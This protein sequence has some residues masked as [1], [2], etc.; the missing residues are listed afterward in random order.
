MVRYRRIELAILAVTRLRATF[1]PIRGYGVRN[2]NWTRATTVTGW[3]VN[4]YTIR[5]SGAVDRIWTYLVTRTPVLQTGTTPHL[6]RYCVW[7]RNSDLNW[8]GLDAPLLLRQVCLPFH[9][10][11]WSGYRELNPDLIRPRDPCYHLHF[12]LKI[13]NPGSLIGRGGKNWTCSFSFGD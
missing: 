13:K 6:R 4:R 12:I 5:T 9:H 2:G 3:R 8:D 10:S 11:G 1:T 7:Y